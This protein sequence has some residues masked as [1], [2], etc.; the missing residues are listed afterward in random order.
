MVYIYVNKR[1]DIN[2]QDKVFSGNDYCSIKIK[3]KKTEDIE[4]KIEV[5]IYNVYN[6]S[7]TF[8]K[9]KDSPLIIPI[10]SEVLRRLGEYI[11]VGDFNL[12]YLQQNDK[13]RYSYYTAADIL[14]E[15]TEGY[16]IVPALLEG[17]VI[18]KVRGSKSA[19]DLVFLA[20]GVYNALKTY[21]TRE[22]LYYRLDYIPVYIE[23][24]QEQKEQ[25][26][27]QRRAW[28]SLENKKTAKK[29]KEGGGRLARILGLPPL[30]TIEA[31]NE[32][33]GQILNS[34]QEIIE[35]NVPWVR[36]ESEERSFQDPACR[37]AV[38]NR[39]KKLKDY[40]RYRYLR[41]E[42]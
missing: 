37:E 23:L 10:I 13:G 9:T 30:E 2:S 16:A 4:E 19:I 15:T 20:L 22:D 38:D 40:Y 6:P 5:Q 34:F 3:L 26:K 8:Y 27:P 21:R 18:Q 41:T 36:L 32:Y 17:L 28:K 11:L 24:E 31:V 12:Y 42:E 25:T 39:K 7:L 29:V 35:Q 1:I 33:L 14:L